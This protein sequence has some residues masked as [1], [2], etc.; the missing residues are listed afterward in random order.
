[1]LFLDDAAGWGLLAVSSGC[2]EEL[3]A[4]VASLE[5]GSPKPYP[6]N[7]QIVDIAVLMIPEMML[8]PVD[9]ARIGRLAFENA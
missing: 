9:R 6:S 3:S 7:D 5:V 1:L 8:Y 2:R 4:G